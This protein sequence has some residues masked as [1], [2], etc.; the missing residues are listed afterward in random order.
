MLEESASTTVK[1]KY[2]SFSSRFHSYI[3]QNHIEDYV[4]DGRLTKNRK[5]LSIE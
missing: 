1:A 2:Y 5:G 4:E 3:Q